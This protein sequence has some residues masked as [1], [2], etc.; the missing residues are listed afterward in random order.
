MKIEVNERFLKACGAFFTDDELCF[1][2]DEFLCI[3]EQTKNANNELDI[4]NRCCFFLG[5]PMY[6]S[7]EELMDSDTNTWCEK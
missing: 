3:M 7:Y 5:D 2:R 6:D 1:I 4:I